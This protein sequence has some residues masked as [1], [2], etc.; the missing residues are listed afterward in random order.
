MKNADLEF[1][2]SP[3]PKEYQTT[4][5]DFDNVSALNYSMSIHGGQYD[6]LLNKQKKILKTIG[7]NVKHNFQRRKVM[8]DQDHITEY[9][10]PNTSIRFDKPF[11]TKTSFHSRKSSLVNDPDLGLKKILERKKSSIVNSRP[12]SPAVSPRKMQNSLAKAFNPIFQISAAEAAA[13]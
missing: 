10:S 5:N 9:G 13:Q 2:P 4:M 1:Y 12:A 8:M 3:T 6:P 11:V 7:N